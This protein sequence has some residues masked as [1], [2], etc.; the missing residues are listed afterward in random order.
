MGILTQINRSNGGLPKRAIAGPVMVGV[1][2]VEGDRQ[3]NLKYHGGRD[4][5]VLMIAAEVVDDL[6]AKGYP[7]VYGSLGEN[8]TVSGL[9][10]D[11][12]RAGQRYRVGE[13]AVIE[14]TTLRRPCA[15]LLV[16][17]SGIGGE[18]YDARCKAGDA[19]SPHWARGGF[20]AR[21]I[22]PGLL[23]AGA[24]VTLESDMA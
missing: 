5:A 8:F 22:K 20:Y 3:L 9:D 10:V 2:G 4:K 19:G 17:G 1:T 23:I 24:P 14:L 21:V 16:F 18:V 6:A 13:D 15:S 12:W 11:R 7:V